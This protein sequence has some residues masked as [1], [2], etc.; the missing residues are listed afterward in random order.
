MVRTNAVMG[1]DPI[2]MIATGVGLGKAIAGFFGGGDN[3]AAARAAR[4]AE[5]A[6]QYQL[7][8]ANIQAQRERYAGQL[9]RSQSSETTKQIGMIVGFGAIAL[10]VIM[11]LR[12][13][14]Q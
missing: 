4:E 12:R 9:S 6:R 3:G 7:E 1:F 5:A 2:S 11:L 13:G 10:G 8:L 14:K